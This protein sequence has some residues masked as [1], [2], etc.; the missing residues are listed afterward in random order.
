MIL[1]KAEIKKYFKEKKEFYTHII[2]YIDQQSKPG[3]NFQNLIL[4]EVQK[5]VENIKDL[6]EFLQIILRISNN[7]Y[8]NADFFSKIEQL[9]IYVT[10]DIKQ[11]F[12]NAEIYRIFK[13]NKHIVL[14]LIEKKIIELDKSIINL[15]L[16]KNNQYAS[17]FYPEISSLIE[18]EKRKALENEIIKNN[19]DNLT[20]FEEK[21][22]NGENDSIICQL[23]RKD[24]IEEFN[25]YVIDQKVSL[26]SK[27][28]PS[29]FET[30]EFLINNEPSLIEYAAFNGSIQIFQYLYA[31]RI[32][33]KPSLWLYGAHGQKNI[34]IIRILEQNH[35]EPDDQSFEKVLEEAIKS[36]H[37]EI[38]KYI[39]DKLMKND[40]KKF[41]IE[42]N[43]SENVFSYAFHYSN[44]LFLPDEFDGN[45]FVFYYACQYNYFDL[46][47]L[48][49]SIDNINI[50][51]PI[52]L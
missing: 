5:Y 4:Y 44:Y 37:N 7:H 38:A 41:N 6:K 30:N 22:K 16:Q 33:L 25:N 9:L 14:F 26:T 18:E 47:K 35:I 27:I 31:N 17:F 29:I 52:I 50:N 13:S 24:S 36:H 11:N 32:E 3:I 45:K 20:N 2:N 21:R 8:H 34:D 28:Q 48:L 19:S 10:K 15:I 23:I 42:N 49:L 40:V 12:K 51:E 43:Y 46:V 1:R 39:F